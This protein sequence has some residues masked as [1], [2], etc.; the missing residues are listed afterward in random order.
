MALDEP[1]TKRS[2]PRELV[3]GEGRTRWTLGVTPR[4]NGASAIVAGPRTCRTRGPVLM[5]Y[6]ESCRH[7]ATL[8]SAALAML[9]SAAHL[10]SVMLAIGGGEAHHASA[11]TSAAASSLHRR[12]GRGHHAF[13]CF[14]T[15]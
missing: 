14:G 5:M 7:R 1:V 4:R 13:A 2:I 15:Q 8:P 6:I 3:L 10:A 12:R 11:W 9:T